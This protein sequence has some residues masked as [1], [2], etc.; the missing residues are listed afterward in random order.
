MAGLVEEGSP[1]LAYQA[2]IS[3]GDFDVYPDEFKWIERRAEHRKPITRRIF[4]KQFPDF[5]WLTV[6]EPLTDLIEELKSER[7]YVDASTAV[8]EFNDGLEPENVIDRVTV[9]RERLSEVTAQHAPRNEIPL[10]SSYEDHLEKINQIRIMRSQGVSLGIPT[11]IP[12]I[13]HH[14]GGL[15]PGRVI[16]VLGRPGDSKSCFIVQLGTAAFL[17]KRRVGLFSPELDEFENNCRVHT[18]LSAIPEIQQEVG[19]RGAFRNRALMDGHGFNRKSY[20]R[21]L[22]YLDTLDG[23]IILF[24]QKYRRTKITPGFIE[25]RIDD[26][27]LDLVIVDPIYK[28]KG[29]RRREN[30]VWELQDITDALAFMAESFNIPVVITNQA[31]RQGNKGD[32]PTKDQSFGSDAPAQEGDH[33]IGLKHFSDERKLVIRCSKNRFG[34]PFR[35]ECAFHPN[36][37]IMKDITPIRGSYKNG[38]DEEEYENIKEV[39]EIE[40]EVTQAEKDE[41]ETQ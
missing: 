3:S 31:F 2:G 33:V 29:P 6:N 30:P 7:A 36:I 12:N 23:E 38:F 24:T 18:W 1:R 13:E 15:L 26:L 39:L 37:G 21:F 35:I 4:K 11:G 9:L 27:G 17:D 34:H 10:I 8:D 28:L 25:S 16:V 5:E 14:L 19:I 32:A 20:K 22:Q 41:L 40:Q